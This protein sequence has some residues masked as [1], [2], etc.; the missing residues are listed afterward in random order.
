MDKTNYS[1][2]SSLEEEAL[3]VQNALMS[4][5]QSKLSMAIND[6]EDAIVFGRFNTSTLMMQKH[7]Y[8]LGCSF[9]YTLMLKETNDLPFSVRSQLILYATQYCLLRYIREVEKG[10][11]EKCTSEYAGALKRAFFCSI[12][13]DEILTI[14]VYSHIS[15][16]SFMGKRIINSLHFKLINSGIKTECDNMT[17][18]LYSKQ[19]L[20]Q[21]SS[22]IN[23]YNEIVE[24]AIVND[25]I[26][27]VLWEYETKV[28]IQ[29]VEDV[30]KEY[31]PF[32]F[33]W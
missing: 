30:K 2:L 1:N 28:L 22:V 6:F 12:M 13:F 29:T 8:L 4:G 20:R 14:G 33:T 23:N 16:G 9:F 26:D 11:R 18:T 5:V 7:Y 15:D 27:K 31:D 3:Q 24:N 19:I 17:E 25:Y 32:G 21:N 10:E